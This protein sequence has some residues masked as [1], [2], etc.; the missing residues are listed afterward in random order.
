MAA[1]KKV[2]KKK[3][4]KKKINRKKPVKPVGRPS[5]YKPE[6]A[7]QLVDYFSVKPG[8]RVGG[9]WVANSLPTL[10]GFCCEIGVHRET[11]LNWA[12]V[13]EEFFDAYKKA[14]DYQEHILIENGLMGG[15]DKSFAIFTAKNLIDWKDKQEHEHSGKI[16]TA[17]QFVINVNAT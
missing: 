1:K 6:Y 10:A 13:H 16:D 15:Y 3:V 17:P 7:K 12:D 9:K 8:S 4:S 14:K 5:S 11:L 2:S